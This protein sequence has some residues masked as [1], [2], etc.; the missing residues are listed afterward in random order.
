MKEFYDD[1]DKMLDLC[2]GQDVDIDEDETD[3]SILYRVT[4]EDGNSEDLNEIE[5]RP[6]IDLQC[7][8]GK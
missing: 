1:S 6:T 4:Y 5:C 3:G 7:M 8:S 2:R